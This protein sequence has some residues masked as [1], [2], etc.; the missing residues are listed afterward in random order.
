LSLRVRKLSVT[1]VVTANFN[2]INRIVFNYFKNNPVGI[3]YRKC[4]ILFEIPLQPMRFKS[5]IE[6]VFLE[7]SKALPQMLFLLLRET[8]QILKPVFFE[9]SVIMN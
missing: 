8:R 6:D 7:D 4:V 3:A 5:F 1:D 9:G 2:K